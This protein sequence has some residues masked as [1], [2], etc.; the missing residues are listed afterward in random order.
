MKIIIICLINYILILY[1][2]QIYF[3]LID[4]I[5]ILKYIDKLKVIKFLFKCL[6]C[7]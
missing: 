7:Y 2:F 6:I 4:T 3:I 1:F 5:I